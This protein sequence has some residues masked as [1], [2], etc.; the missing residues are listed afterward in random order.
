[1]C[2]SPV[3]AALRFVCAEQLLQA[4]ERSVRAPLAEA[5]SVIRG[6]VPGYSFEADVLFEEPDRKRQSELM[7]AVYAAKEEALV[8]ALLA[9]DPTGAELAEAYSSGGPHAADYMM[10]RAPGE[11]G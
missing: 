9:E 6:I 5:A 8:P 4:A 11:P 2:L 1:M 3:A 10:P 7:D